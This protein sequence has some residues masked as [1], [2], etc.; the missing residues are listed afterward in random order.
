MN[1]IADMNH[2]VSIFR[3]DDYSLRFNV[4]RERKHN[5]IFYSI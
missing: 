4:V 2:F 1:N 5:E 3:T